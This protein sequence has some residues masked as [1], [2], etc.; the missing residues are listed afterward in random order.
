MS[1]SK[2]S[3]RKVKLLPA[4][5]LEVEYNRIET[6]DATA[7]VTDY[8]AKF[9]DAEVHPDLTDAIRELAPLVAKTIGLTA[10]LPVA[11][12]LNLTQE[13][14]EKFSEL[15]DEQRRRIDVR[16]IALSGD[17]EDEGVVITSVLETKNGL[18]TCINT[19][20][21]KYHQESY[22]FE[23]RLDYLVQKIREEVRAFIVEGKTAAPSLF[24]GEE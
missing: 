15:A 16:G 4:G 8:K 7:A 6:R 23:D 12:D 24:G 10:F 3:L 2:F 13:A 17:D 1:E 5:G 21:I 22:G 14:R 9:E 18:K 11:A 19:P 20:R